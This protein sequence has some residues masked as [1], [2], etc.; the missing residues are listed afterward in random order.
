MREIRELVKGAKKGDKFFF[1]C[2]CNRT[3]T[4]PCDLIKALDAGEG[5]QAPNKTNSEEDG[6]DECM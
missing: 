3:L 6:M 4:A 1:H 5:G 2:T